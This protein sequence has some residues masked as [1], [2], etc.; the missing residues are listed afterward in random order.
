[1]KTLYLVRHSKSSWS[2]NGISDRD[3]PLKGRGIKDAHLVS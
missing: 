2:I 3:R 1:M